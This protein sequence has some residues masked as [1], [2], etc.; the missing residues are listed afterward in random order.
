MCVQNWNFHH[1]EDPPSHKKIGIKIC[2]IYAV[3]SSLWIL[4]SDQLAGYFASSMEEL[5]L[6]I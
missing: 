3:L 2:V 1:I 5:I 4:F 6:L